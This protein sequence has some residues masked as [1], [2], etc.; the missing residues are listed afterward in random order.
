ME[1]EESDFISL[2]HFT[3]ERAELKTELPPNVMT[4][5][6]ASFI[7]EHTEIKLSDIRIKILNKRL[8]EKR[9]KPC[10]KT[11]ILHVK[12]LKNKHSSKE[13]KLKEDIKIL[14]S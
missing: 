9:L 14:L 10:I 13:E 6:V 2:I 7:K 1:L 5:G 11:D 4:N 12:N 8:E 3:G